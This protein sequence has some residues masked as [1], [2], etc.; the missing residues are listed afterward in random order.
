MADRPSRVKFRRRLSRD[1]R[2]ATAVEYGMIVA[3]IVL[4]LLAGL[5]SLAAETTGMWGG[6]SDRVVHA[7]DQ[8]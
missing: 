1:T 2:G 5:R 4:V 8:S 6:V 7:G 3:M